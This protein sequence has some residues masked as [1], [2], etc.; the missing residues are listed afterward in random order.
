MAY[1]RSRGNT[2]GARGRSGRG[3][4]GGYGGGRKSSVRSG[5]RSGGRNMSRAPT[6]Q[7]VLHPD[8]FSGGVMAPGVAGAAAKIAAP[9][10]AKPRPF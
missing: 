4:S 9:V 10:Q 2:R 3:R 6:V 5:S 1:S 7:I 8:M